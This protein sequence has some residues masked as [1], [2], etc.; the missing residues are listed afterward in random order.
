MAE[1]GPAAQ[2]STA[3]NKKKAGFIAFSSVE[4]ATEAINAG[5]QEKG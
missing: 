4:R 1:A 3:A 2:D 5:F